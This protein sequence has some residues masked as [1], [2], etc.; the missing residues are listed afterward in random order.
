MHLVEN[1]LKMRDVQHAKLAP[2]LEA[3]G[4]KVEWHAHIDEVPQTGEHLTHRMPSS[5]DGLI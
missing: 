4:I 1:S 5:G 2:R 3:H